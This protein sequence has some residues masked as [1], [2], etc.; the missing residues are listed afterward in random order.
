MILKHFW[1][2]R[3]TVTN[4]MK[5]YVMKWRKHLQTLHLTVVWY[6][7]TYKEFKN[8]I[9]TNYLILWAIKLNRHISRRHTKWLMGTWKKKNQTKL[10]IT[11]HEGKAN[12]NHQK[13][14]AYPVLIFILKT[15]KKSGVCIWRRE[16]AQTVGET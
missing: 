15:P 16:S 2:T 9:K 10:N 7:K 8:S 4:S 1:S 3:K 13:V 5:D 6:L 11:N 14:A 12:E